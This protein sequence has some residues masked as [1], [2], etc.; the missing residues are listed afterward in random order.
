MVHKIVIN[1]ASGSYSKKV[2]MFSKG[3]SHRFSIFS[4]GLFDFDLN[5][6]FNVKLF[7]FTILFNSKFL[8]SR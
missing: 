1:D 7:K 4:C 8:M 5:L 3:L 2:F 6:A